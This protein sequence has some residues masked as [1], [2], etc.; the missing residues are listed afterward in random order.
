METLNAI[1]SKTYNFV[2]LRAKSIFN[3]EEDA[4]QLMKEIF[5]KAMEED[6]RE[7]RLYAWLGRQ[8]YS[9]GCSKFRK[10]KVREADFIELEENE[11]YASNSVY[12]EKTVE[13]ICDILEELPDMYQATLYAFYYDHLT[14]KEVAN[15]MGYSQKA[16]LN[17]LNYS[18]KYLS[19]ALKMQGEERELDLEF[20][21]EALCQALKEWSLK[22]KLD[23]DVA[24]NIFGSICREL[25]IQ[26]EYESEE[27][28]LSGA[29]ECMV[30][31][32]SEIDAVIEEMEY[33]GEY[34]KLNPKLLLG[35]GG[36][37]VLILVIVLLFSCGKSKEQE[38]APEQNSDNQE[39]YM[40]EEF[41]EEWTDSSDE[42]TQEQQDVVDSTAFVLPNSSVEYLTAADLEG[43]NSE[44]LQIAINEIYARQHVIFPEADT[45][46]YF[47]GK[48]WYRNLETTPI[49]WDDF[50][51]GKTDRGFNEIEWANIKLLI[52]Q[53]DKVSE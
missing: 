36:A 48:E 39:E 22:N 51:E 29:D 45:Q 14:I 43:L 23:E 20:S 52:D 34:T 1:Y 37:A 8:V 35:I 15:F 11:Y 46:A 44:Q 17:R 7:D 32:E 21:V 53:Q 9:L 49:S 4:Q 31:K 18:H 38:K 3:K 41:D 19:K 13:A 6:V 2:Y 50:N 30:K 28:S 10:K 47:E 24:Q 42:G 26:S 12:M 27:E 25:S 40:E 16:I 5:V 33:Y